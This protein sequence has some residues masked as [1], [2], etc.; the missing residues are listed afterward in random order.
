MHACVHIDFPTRLF[1]A[2]AKLWLEKKGEQAKTPAPDRENSTSGPVMR[3]PENINM[4]HKHTHA[5]GY[6]PVWF[7]SHF[8]VVNN[9]SWPKISTY[10]TKLPKLKT[11]RRV[12][13]QQSDSLLLKQQDWIWGLLIRS[14]VQPTKIEKIKEVTTLL[15]GLEIG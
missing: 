9:M 14:P 2:E 5:S 7:Y 1:T 4:R 3:L 12:S 8:A 15:V 6:F 10:R 11:R 13:S